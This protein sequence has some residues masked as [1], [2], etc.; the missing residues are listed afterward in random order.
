MIRFLGAVMAALACL[1][2]GN[3]RAV[4]LHVRVDALED[5]RD[6]LEQ[7]RREL[8]LRSTPLPQLMEELGKRTTQPSGQLFLRCRSALDCLR[9]ERFFRAWT[10]A[11][12][13]LTELTAGDKRVLIP[14]GEVLGQYGNIG[15]AELLVRVRE[16]LDRGIS[17]AREEYM[18]LGRV[19]RVAGAAAGG[20]FVI[21]FL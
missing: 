6:G 3:Q 17:S 10:R 9:E 18:R 11:V 2:L 5:L 20:F 1:W 8:E 19:Y 21:L 12:E 15:Q 16:E 4:Q 7:L 14:V 13:D